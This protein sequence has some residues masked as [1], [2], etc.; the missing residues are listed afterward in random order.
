MPNGRFNIG[1]VRDIIEEL[2]CQNNTVVLQN[3]M[4]ERVIAKLSLNEFKLFMA[5]MSR[6]QY[7]KLNGTFEMARSELNILIS[8]KLSMKDIDLMLCS[9]KDKIGILEKF[10]CTDNFKTVL[11]RI[12]D[13]GVIERDFTK[14]DF[15]AV[16]QIRT[17]IELVAYFYLTRYSDLNR[18]CIYGSDLYKKFDIK[19]N[20]NR[21]NKII[22]DILQDYSKAY[23]LKSIEPIYRNKK[24][25]YLEISKR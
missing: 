14:L 23:G 20:F 7:I 5:F 13:I 8:K 16:S 12:G 11:I 18:I 3:A 25:A 9:I 2:N 4:W 15:Y 24:I 17:K 10:L 21:A 19:T 22:I 6:Y 1:V